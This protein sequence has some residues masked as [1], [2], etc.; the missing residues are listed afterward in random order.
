MRK[1][2]G[3]RDGLT[4]PKLTFH[5]VSGAML[6]TV[7]AVSLIVT[8]GLFANM[9]AASPSPV[10]YASVF[11]IVSASI[12]GVGSAITGALFSALDQT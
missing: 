3:T 5:F 6:G 11:V 12:I 8:H 4:A 2:R 7:L 10:L 1:R 9:L